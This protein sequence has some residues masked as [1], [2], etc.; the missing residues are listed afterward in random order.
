[1]LAYWII[2]IYLAILSVLHLRPANASSFNPASK[3]LSWYLTF[4]LLTLV[5]GLR[6]NVG[7]DWDTYQEYIYEMEGQS[8]VLALAIGDPAYSLLNWVAANYF[9]GIYLVNIICAAI[10]S[11]GVLALAMAQPRPWLALVVST[12]FLITVVAMGYTRQSVAIGLFMTSLP[13]LIRGQI[14]KYIVFVMLAALFH[15]TAAILGFLALPEVLRRKNGVILFLI[16]T[17]VI[18]SILHLTLGVHLDRLVQNYLISDYSAGGANIR[19]AMVVMP[20][21]IFLIFKNRSGMFEEEKRFWYAM[22]IVAF[23]F[24]IFLF[25]FNSAVAVDRLALYWIPLQMVVLCRLPELIGAGSGSSHIWI[26]LVLFYSAFVM[27]VWL[28]FADHAPFWIPYN[29]YPWIIFWT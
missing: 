27:F 18:L 3:G 13:N 7:G 21:V 25:F 2:Y 17:F 24:V 20:A 26:L 19:I 29:F 4:L 8:L 10:F 16:F 9:G 6:H 1:M 5:I 12:S 22:S 15:S 28:A 14:L 11:W 23:S